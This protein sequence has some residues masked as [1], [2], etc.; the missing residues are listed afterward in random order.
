MAGERRGHL[1]GRHLGRAQDRR[2]SSPGSHADQER[3]RRGQLEHAD[4][5]GRGQRESWTTP[6]GI[7]LN[8]AT[9]ETIAGATFDLKTDADLNATLGGAPSERFLNGGTLTKSAG[10]ADSIDRGRAGQHQCGDG[11]CRDAVADRRRRGRL[12]RRAALPARARAGSSSGA[13]SS[14]WRQRP[15]R[16]STTA[17]SI[18]SG[19]SRA[20]AR[21][22]STARSPGRAAPGQGTGQTLVVAGETLTKSGSGGA[23]LNTRTLRVEGNAVVDDTGGL[24]LLNG[25]T[26]ETIAGGDLRPEDGRRSERCRAGR[27]RSGS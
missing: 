19:R 26:I 22:A 24:T 18:R 3:L 9:I 27:R 15:R 8:G 21:G 5:A 11:K 16:P 17:S 20:Q 4:T 13:A 14:T 6:V 1:D 10:T 23:S 2:W 25:A 7:T 12:R